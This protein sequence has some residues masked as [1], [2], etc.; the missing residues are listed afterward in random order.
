MIRGGWEEK[1][2]REEDM[3]LTIGEEERNK[4]G[5]IRRCDEEERE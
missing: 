5:E 1:R 4:K 3:T 2:R